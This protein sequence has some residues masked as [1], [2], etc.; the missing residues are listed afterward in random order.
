VQENRTTL[1]EIKKFLAD[2]S[3]RFLGFQL[4]YRM[5]QKYAAR[6]PDDPAMVDLDHW[7]AF[8]QDMPYT[9]A[10]MYRFWIQKPE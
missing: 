10:G 1:P 3:M 6:F 7:H 5:Q 9:F 8:E 2:S 4:E